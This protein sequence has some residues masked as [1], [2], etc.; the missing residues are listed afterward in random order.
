MLS[1]LSECDD[2]T[3]DPFTRDPR[4]NRNQ[5]EDLK[6]AIDYLYELKTELSILHPS[7]LPIIASMIDEVF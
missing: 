5:K 7:V 6:R 3:R 1:V 4:L 2:V